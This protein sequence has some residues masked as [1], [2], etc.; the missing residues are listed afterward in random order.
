MPTTRPKSPKL[1]RKKAAM[2]TSHSSEES[3]STRPC[4]R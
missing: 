2:N 3:E 4:C 1:G